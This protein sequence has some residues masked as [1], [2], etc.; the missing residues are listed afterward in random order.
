MTWIA[1]IFTNGWEWVA[2]I[3]A[4]AVALVSVY[5]GGKKIG[6]VQT[7]AKADVAATEK[8]IAQ[9]QAIAKKQS[10]NIEVAKNVESENDAL[11]DDA[12]RDKLRK[13]KYNS[14]D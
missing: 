11:T 12:S 1:S 8:E 10:D 13:S 14:E 9:I 4:A 5:F 6:T 2:G 7:Q 3:A